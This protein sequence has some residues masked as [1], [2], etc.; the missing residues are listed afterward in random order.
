M[1]NLLFLLA[2]FVFPF[3][4][5]AQIAGINWGTDYKKKTASGKGYFSKNYF[6][7]SKTYYYFLVKENLKKRRL[8]K[9]NYNNEIVEE[10][11]LDFKHNGKLIKYY[12]MISTVSGNFVLGTYYDKKKKMAHY[13]TYQLGNGSPKKMKLLCSIPYQNNGS[14]RDS[15]DETDYAG[16]DIS[17]DSSLVLFSNVKK[18]TEFKQKKEEAYNFVVL[19]NELNLKWE[20]KTTIPFIDKK[21]LI[22]DINI[23]N[24]GVISVL[25]RVDLKKAKDKI[26]ASQFEYYLFKVSKDGSQSKVKVKP[27]EGFIND[28]K[29]VT[30]KDGTE[31]IFG[32]YHKREKKPITQHGFF[33]N[34]YNEKGEEIFANVYPWS[35]EI[36]NH[37][38]ENKHFTKLGTFYTENYHVFNNKL[39]FFTQRK[40]DYHDSDRGSHLRKY[41]T[42]TIIIPSFYFDGEMSW[43]TLIKKQMIDKEFKSLITL[44]RNENHYLMFNKD[45]SGNTFSKGKSAG[46]F[47]GIN[48]KY[49][50]KLISI[51]NKGEVG[52]EQIIFE[53]DEGVFESPK[54][55]LWFQGAQKL[56]NNMIL[57][58]K[59]IVGIGKKDY[60]HGL[61]K[62]N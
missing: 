60:R 26:T 58:E 12:E 42:S 19:D 59:R 53:K 51:N 62:L 55:Y 52:K 9:F 40:I 35:D 4:Q 3:L 33:L 27:H 15:E 20:L 48:E 37:I 43:M 29:I 14:P 34:K 54:D 24:Q 16:I 1:K 30:L 25:G 50:T 39:T 31:F 11:E 8:F 38:E 18:I 44:H 57:L 5:Q 13:Y 6:G 22:T 46:L 28:P 56:D 32:G 21:I 23:S 7:T 17:L 2:L 36:Y 49:V 45:N 10:I 41:Q 47:D 61:L